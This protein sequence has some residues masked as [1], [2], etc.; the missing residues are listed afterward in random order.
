M[1]AVPG[2]AAAWWAG[3]GAAKQHPVSAAP[4]IKHFPGC[5]PWADVR[6]C[7]CCTAPRR[8]P[9]G[10]GPGPCRLPTKVCSRRCCAAPRRTPTRRQQRRP[11]HPDLQLCAAAVVN[12]V[13]AE[14]R[15]LPAVL[16]QDLGN[17]G[18]GGGVDG[19]AGGARRWRRGWGVGMGVEGEG[20]QGLPSSPRIALAAVTA[21]GAWQSCTSA[22]P[23]P[24]LQIDAQRRRPSRGDPLARAGAA[25]QVVARSVGSV[26]I[27][28]GDLVLLR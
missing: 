2:V 25:N 6:I 16:H 18:E 5:P 28:G 11:L 14:L 17:G 26:V 15:A 13:P 23:R 22:R 10:I 9:R 1:L 24:P 20:V 8:P 12:L 19:P 27:G 7:N 21:C 3:G 4:H